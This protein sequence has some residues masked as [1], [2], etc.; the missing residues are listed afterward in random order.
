[1][2]LYSDGLWFLVIVL[3][4]LSLSAS[5]DCRD[6][7]GVSAWFTCVKKEAVIP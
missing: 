1:M 5:A 6:K 4:A 7:G 3:F 2:K